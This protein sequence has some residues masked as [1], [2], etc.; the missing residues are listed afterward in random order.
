MNL[1]VHFCILYYSYL[2]LDECY[3]QDEQVLESVHFSVED[4]H[5]LQLIH[6]LEYQVCTLQRKLNY[7]GKYQSSLL[8][9]SPP[10]KGP[11][12]GLARDIYKYMSLGLAKNM[13]KTF[14]ATMTYF[15]TLS[16][17]PSSGDYGCGNKPTI[18]VCRG[19]I[20]VHCTH[21]TNMAM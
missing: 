7:R 12:M 21:N 16:D 2:V 6:R 3:N 5:R 18:E 4:I 10:L 8:A 17:I 1:K 13:F 11:D 14:Q 15:Q 9:P 20:Q 19:Q